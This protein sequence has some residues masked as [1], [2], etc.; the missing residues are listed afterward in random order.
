MR[1]DDP[2]SLLN[3]PACD[4]PGVPRIALAVAALAAMAA[5]ALPMFLGFARGWAACW[6]LHA[7]VMALTGTVM[8]ERRAQAR[9]APPTPACASEH[10]T[11]NV[12]RIPRR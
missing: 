12:P 4:Q 6:L 7:L 8:G 3:R 5:L 9:A 10:H 1:T 11:R 2:Q